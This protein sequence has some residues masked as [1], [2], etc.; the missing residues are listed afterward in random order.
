MSEQAKVPE[1]KV[2]TSNLSNFK[3][4]RLSKKWEHTEM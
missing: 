1:M 4:D 2:V 3:A